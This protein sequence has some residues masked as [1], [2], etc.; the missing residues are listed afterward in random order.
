MTTFG[1]GSKNEVLARFGI[2][3]AQKYEALSVGGEAGRTV[4]VLDQQLWGP[5]QHGRAV[6]IVF[7]GGSSA[8]QLGV[9]I[10]DVAAVGSETQGVVLHS[11]RAHDLHIAVAGQM[12]K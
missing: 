4:N 8:G 6:E 5:A 9:R 7:L 1:V 2:V 10:V 12:A 3:G 11:F